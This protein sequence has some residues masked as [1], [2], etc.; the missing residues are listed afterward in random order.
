M[1]PVKSL[2]VLF[3]FLVFVPKSGLR[4]FDPGGRA[5]GG[6]PGRIATLKAANVSSCEW[7]PELLA[8]TAKQ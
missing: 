1:V 5:S 4:F 8:V 2:N 3:R 6:S 7:N